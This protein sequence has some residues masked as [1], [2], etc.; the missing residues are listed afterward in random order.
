MYS[1]LLEYGAN[2]SLPEHD[3]QISH[4]DGLQEDCD[5]FRLIFRS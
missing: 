5:N 2:P 1:F 4:V 3:S